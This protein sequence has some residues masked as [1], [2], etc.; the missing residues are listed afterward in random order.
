[1]D[2]Q[3]PEVQDMLGFSLV[4]PE[5][6]TVRTVHNVLVELDCV[7]VLRDDLVGAA[8]MEIIA[9]GKERRQVQREIKMK[10]RAVEALA[11]KYG[12]KTARGE[13]S[14]KPELIRQVSLIIEAPS[15]TPRLTRIHSYSAFTALATIMPSFALT[16]IRATR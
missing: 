12:A 6:P 7:E 5:T 14:A 3:T 15:R 16:V 10:E 11:S 8:T 2:A 1:M 9:E 4:D 13:R